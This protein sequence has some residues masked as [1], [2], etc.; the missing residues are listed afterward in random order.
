[1]SVSI[2]QPNDLKL[3]FKKFNPDVVQ[4]PLNIFNQNFAKKNLLLKLKK[5][6]IIIQARSIFLQGLLL[7]NY[8]EINKIKCNK[9]LKDK[10]INFSKWC[11]SSKLTQ[12]HACIQ[13]IKSIKYI[14]FIILGINTPDQL[15][16]IIRVL[17]KKVIIKNFNKFY[18][19]DKNL[20]DPRKW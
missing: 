14:D 3:V 15:K 6:K 19:K 17:K 9:K 4:I 16:E 20:T 18:I 1:V 8:E 12:V 2:Y 11:I 13:Y 10:L 5:K 7:K